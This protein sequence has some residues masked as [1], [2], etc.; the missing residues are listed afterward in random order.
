M[1]L[2]LAWSVCLQWPS[3]RCRWTK[4]GGRFS[5]LYQVWFSLLSS[6]GKLLLKDFQELCKPAGV[7]TSALQ[8]S[9]RVAGRSLSLG[10]G[11]APQQGHSHGENH[12]PITLTVL[13][14]LSTAGVMLASNLTMGL[15]IHF[16]PASHNS[17]VANTSL[18]ISANLPAGPTNYITLIPLLATM[19]FIMGRCREHRTG[20]QPGEDASHPRQGDVE[21]GD[22]VWSWEEGRCPW[23]SR[24]AGI[25]SHF[26]E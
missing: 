20:H 1:Q 6:Q 8:C 24:K 4:L 15:Y 18:A 16:V 2:W 13:L 9:G 21:Q 26:E 5:F 19:F 14:P 10:G 3:L 11:S 25:C 17:T 23:K 12:S 7:E 22:W